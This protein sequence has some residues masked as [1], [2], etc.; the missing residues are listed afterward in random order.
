MKE[1]EQSATVVDVQ[2]II[3]IDD[4]KVKKIM[5]GDVKMTPNDL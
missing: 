1:R 4:C 3:L 2:A 5:K